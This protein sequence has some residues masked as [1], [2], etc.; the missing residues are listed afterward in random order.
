MV[1]TF[2]DSK[3]LSYTNHVPRV[4]TLNANYIVDAMG[5]LLKVFK[6]KRPVMRLWIGG[7][8]GIIL[9]CTP[10]PWRLTGWRPGRSR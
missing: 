5:K 7:F 9:L 6:H 3:G 8:I 2:F 1:L 10:P 4:T